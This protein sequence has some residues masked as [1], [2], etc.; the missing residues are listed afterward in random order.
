MTREEIIEYLDS[1]VGTYTILLGHGVNS[2]VL[3]TDDIEAINE[4]IRIIKAIE[5]IKAEIEQ[6]CSITVG[7][8]NEP[9]MTL[10]DIFEIFDKHINE[11]GTSKSLPEGSKKE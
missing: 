4:S 6:H 9:A 7:A 10:H 3:D 8:D 11:V 1:I 2:D 5:D